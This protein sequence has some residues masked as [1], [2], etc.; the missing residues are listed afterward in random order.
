MDMA[1][2]FPESESTRIGWRNETC[3]YLLPT[4]SDRHWIATPYY[5]AIVRPAVSHNL[6]NIAK[7]NS[8]LAKVSTLS[9]YQTNLDHKRH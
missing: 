7:P 8:F 9:R 3:H 6:T 1:E 4:C 2:Y 5:F